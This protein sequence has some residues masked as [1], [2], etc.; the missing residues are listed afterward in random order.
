[1]PTCN[2]QSHRCSNKKLEHRAF[3]LHQEEDQLLWRRRAY[4]QQQKAIQK[5]DEV[6]ASEVAALT[7][8]GNADPERST[9]D[10]KVSHPKP[11]SP[12]RSSAWD[13]LDQI[14]ISLS[15]VATGVPLSAH[16]FK[17]P[18]SRAEEFPLMEKIFQVRS[19]NA[20]ISRVSTSSAQ[21]RARREKSSIKAQELLRQL[22]EAAQLWKMRADEFDPLGRSSLYETGG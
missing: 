4:E 12:S 10:V 7:L 20:R 16:D 1:M 8:F 22:L 15:A 6:L 11:S 18:T 19:L 21:L 17:R 2:C 9:S 14:D 3:K 13:E 5:H